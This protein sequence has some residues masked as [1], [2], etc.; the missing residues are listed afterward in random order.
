[1]KAVKVQYTVQPDFVEQNKAN[2]SKVMD[3]LRANPIPGMQY[4]SFTVGDGQTFVHVNMAADEATMAKLNDVREFQEFQTALKAS[5]PIT[6]PAVET[7]NLVAA[8]FD[9]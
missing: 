9:V 5:Q 2:I 1:M 6:P 7:M 3:T 8:G 4:S